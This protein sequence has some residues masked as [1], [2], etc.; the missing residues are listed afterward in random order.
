MC[1]SLGCRHS[2]RYSIVLLVSGSKTGISRWSSDVSGVHQSASNSFGNFSW[3]ACAGV[4]V[5]ACLSCDRVRL[6]MGCSA[7]WDWERG[8]ASHWFLV[9]LL[10]GVHP[11]SRCRYLILNVHPWSWLRR[12][13]VFWHP[14]RLLG[15]LGLLRI[16]QPWIKGGADLSVHVL[17]TC[18]G[19]VWVVS[20][21]LGH[22][23]L[24]TLYR[25][26]VVL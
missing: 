2:W 14:W 25:Y 26:P 3:A 23:Y 7:G 5:R 24:P 21:L 20:D 11:W 19:A 9:W 6:A 18:K 17:V 16:F 12:I 22:Q 1:L 13:V 15:L 4:T 10:L 8:E